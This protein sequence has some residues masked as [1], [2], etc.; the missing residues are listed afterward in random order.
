M[1]PQQ[2]LVNIESSI[3]LEEY[4]ELEKCLVR[5]LVKRSTKLLAQNTIVPDLKFIANVYWCQSLDIAIDG[6]CSPHIAIF[7]PCSMDISA[8][9]H[10]HAEAVVIP[11]CRIR[12]IYIVHTKAYLHCRYA[13]STLY[14]QILHCTM[15][16]QISLLYRLI[17]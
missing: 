12:H 13:L 14:V 15:Y 1:L 7:F 17:S 6:V 3:V 8:L 4:E 16:T 5:H 10:R 9:V 2:L 11:A